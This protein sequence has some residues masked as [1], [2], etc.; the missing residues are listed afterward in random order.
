M[1]EWLDLPY[2]TRSNCSADAMRSNC[3]A[4]LTRSNCAGDRQLEAASDNT[5]THLFTISRVA[6]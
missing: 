1:A 6:G 2:A 4:N 5:R 3:G